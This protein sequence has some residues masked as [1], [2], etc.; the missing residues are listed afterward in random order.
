MLFL[1]N[2][3]I[4]FI[5]IPFANAQAQNF[6][7]IISFSHFLIKDFKSSC[8][9]IS[10]NREAYSFVSPRGGAFSQKLS[11]I[12]KFIHLVRNYTGDSDLAEH[13]RAPGLFILGANMQQPQPANLN[14]SG[15]KKLIHP[16]VQLHRQYLYSRGAHL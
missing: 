6:M 12:K 13:V 16:S 14:I 7:E 5:S 10:R 8:L 2:P 9:P 11:R 1:L 4:I 3:F 15:I